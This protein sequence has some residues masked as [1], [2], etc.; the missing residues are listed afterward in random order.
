[1]GG[2]RGCGIRDARCGKVRAVS[3]KKLEVWQLA[4][5]VSVGVHRMTVDL[6]G[7]K[8]NQFIQSVESQHLSVREEEVGYI[9]REEIE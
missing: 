4:R 1:M 9:V 6:L 3:Y 8:L 7:G 5:D 2:Y